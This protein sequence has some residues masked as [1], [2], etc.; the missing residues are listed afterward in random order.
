MRESQR[1]IA[2][3]I[4]EVGFER[5]RAIAIALPTG[6]A[7]KAGIYRKIFDGVGKQ[8]TIHHGIVLSSV[9]GLPAEKTATCRDAEVVFATLKVESSTYC[10]IEEVARSIVAT[11]LGILI[12]RSCF[13]CCASRDV[14]VVTLLRKDA[15]I[16]R[17][18]DI[19]R[20]HT[21]QIARMR[22]TAQGIDLGRGVEVLENRHPHRKISLRREERNSQ[23]GE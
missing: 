3:A 8:Q 16:G 13:E 23:F 15:Y 1:Q 6:I 20:V 22:Q 17:E 18:I 19:A 14:Y 7:T 4:R 12:C 5:H 21:L 10:R 2:N 9:V 11:T